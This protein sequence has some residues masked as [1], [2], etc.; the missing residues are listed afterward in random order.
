MKPKILVFRVSDPKDWRNGYFASGSAVRFI[1]ELRDLGEV[2]EAPFATEPEERMRLARAHDI[3]VSTP[4]PLLPDALARDPGRLKYVCCLHGGI[5][6]VVSR[7]L[8]QAGITVTNWGDSPGHGLASLSMTL[9]LALLR[10]LPAQ[11]DEVRQKRWR[12]D[13]HCPVR[14]RV[15]GG[16]AEDLRVG[17]YGLGFAG[18]AFLPMARGMGFVLSGYDP[19]VN[20]WPDGVRR[21]DSL[22][23][24]FDDIDALVICAAL[25]DETRN[26]VT[27]E[28]LARLPD[29]GIVINTARGGIIEQDALFA[30]LLNGRLRA[31]LDVL[32]PDH[33]DYLEPDH[34][35]RQL[36]NCILTCHVG[37][38]NR[39]S[40][41]DLGRNERYALENI[42]RFIAGQPL[43]WVVDLTRYSRMT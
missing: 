33:V 31:G 36:P 24:L 34:P 38:T 29:G 27:R 8:L 40:K 25:T 9:L 3:L 23:A 26:T 37:P 19:Y 1:A 42:R 30:E 4:A 17:I 13:D 28:L 22:P 16:Q 2:T 15:W 18:R 41:P 6:G 7:D 35:V 32:A 20:P 14:E 39:F 12:L 21:A 43:Q 10:E 11:I 5:R